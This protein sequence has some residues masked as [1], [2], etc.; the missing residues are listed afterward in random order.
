M[1]SS[2]RRQ[3]ERDWHWLYETVARWED[4]RASFLEY[5]GRARLGKNGLRPLGSRTP[6][7]TRTVKTEGKRISKH[8]RGVATET[9]P[10]EAVFARLE[11]WF[12]EERVHRHEVRNKSLAT[13]LRFEMEFERDKQLVLEQHKSPE[14]RPYVLERVRDKLSWFQITRPSK[15]QE[16]WISDVVRPRI[17]A[18]TRAAQKLNESTDRKLDEVKAKLTWATADRLVHLIARGEPEALRVFCSEPEVFCENRAQTSVVVCDATALWV[19]LRGEDK[20]LVHEDEKTHEAERKRMVRAS[21]KV[22]K[23]NREQVEE[24]E[25]Q[26]QAFFDSCEQNED[27]RGQVESC[28][29]SAG[30]KYRLTLI[31]ISGVEGW[32][33]PN[34]SP[35]ASKKRSILLVPCARHCRVS[36]MDLET[37]QWLRDVQYEKSDGEQEHFKQG[38]SVGALLLGWRRALLEFEPEERQRVLKYLDVWGQ[39]R[40]WTDELIASW[41]VQHIRAEW[42]QSLVFAD[43]LASQWTES[44]CLQAWLQNVVWAPYAPDVTSFLQEPDTHEHSQ[45]K[46]KIREVKSELHWALEQEWLNKQKTVEGRKA[47][48]PSSWGPFEC[49]FV[50]S[51][52]YERFCEETRGKVPLEGLQA[53]Q[54]LR[55]RPTSAEPPRLELVTGDEPWSFCVEAGRGIPPRLKKERDLLVSSWEGN[56]PPEPDWAWLD[57]HLFE[58]DDEVDEPAPQD[59]VLEVAFST[60]ELTEHQ[61]AM[62]QPPEK[63]LENLVFPAS[64]A[65]R[66]VKQRKTR[67]KS[68]WAAKFRGHFVGKSAKKWSARLASGSH[69]D[70]KREARGKG[71]VKTR[72]VFKKAETPKP[73]AEHLA[74]VGKA[75]SKCKN[76]ARALKSKSKKEAETEHTTEVAESPWLGRTIRVVS[77]ASAHEGR[78]GKVTGVQRYEGTEPPEFR[79]QATAEAGE[80]AGGVFLARSTQVE[81]ERDEYEAARPF[82][83]DYRTLRKAEREAR[84]RRRRRRQRRRS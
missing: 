55:V 57:G 47:K 38:E 75:T 23:S 35:R 28:Y 19:K 52:A 60:L 56:E 61:K 79:L 59:L 1:P 17:R 5:V 69:E 4:L 66:A 6:T 25:K 27:V 44:V 64:L 46:A 48:Y 24:F 10:L 9:R 33:E 70:L 73:L 50:V 65:S 81:V 8:V 54:M 42:G 20:V 82:K 12:R 36:D 22:D 67:R 11:A 62:L 83:L 18:T 40:A 30:D 26:K 76:R 39:P 31:N 63:R 74:E 84:G 51:K 45:L 37:G 7:S 71:K 58:Q 80:K 49:L 13:R 72:V 16:R 77:E 15:K 41:C 3:L 68:R 14:F 34:E 29:S 78:V 43:C 2:K 53:N 21:K 32:F